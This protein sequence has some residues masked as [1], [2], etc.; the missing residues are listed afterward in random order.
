M[1]DQLFERHAACR[2]APPSLT[3][4]T[5]K[6]HLMLFMMR[7]LITDDYACVR[8]NDPTDFTTNYTKAVLIVDD[9]LIAT[10]ATSNLYSVYVISFPVSDVGSEGAQPDGSGSHQNQ[11]PAELRNLNYSDVKT[12]QES[13]AS[14]VA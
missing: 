9:M 13:I 4:S 11:C 8:F 6:A 3:T 7:Q 12:C 14:T 1:D 5:L 2:A 10:K